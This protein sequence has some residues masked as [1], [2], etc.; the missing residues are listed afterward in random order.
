M[1]CVMNA[2]S[3]PSTERAPR[4]ARQAAMETKP[5]IALP[6]LLTMWAQR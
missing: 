3:M 2:A 5:K 6:V 1:Y 4:T